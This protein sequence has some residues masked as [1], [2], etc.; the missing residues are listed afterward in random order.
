MYL[1]LESIEGCFDV[2]DIAE[3][4]DAASKIGATLIHVEHDFND[5]SFKMIAS[6]V[7]GSEKKE[8]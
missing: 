4:V 3:F 1:T 6:V 5:H 8:K 7:L 2:R